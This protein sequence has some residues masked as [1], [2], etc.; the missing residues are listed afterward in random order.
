[1]IAN[2]K[3]EIPFVILILPFL[4][5]ITIGLNFPLTSGIYWLS[6]IFVFLGIAFI[7]L[8][9]TYSR[10]KLYRI[11]WAGG[12]ILHI[13]LFL[14]G[15]ICV[16]SYNELNNNHHFTKA[17]GQYLAV[18]INN[19]PNIRN[20][21]IRF[22]ADV[23][24]RIS[25][26]KQQATTGTLLIAIKDT[27]AYNVY[28]GDQLLIPANYTP[29]EPPYNPA[30]FNYKK[31]LANQNIYYQ[32]FLYPKQFKIL[33][34][35]AGNR[36][37][38]FSLHLRQ[39]LVGK[40]K[41]NMPDT[42][43]IAVASTLIL[44]YKADLSNDILQAYSKTGTIHVLSVSGAHVAIIYI[45]LNLMLGFLNKLPRGKLIKALLIITL[46]WYYSLLSGFSPAV[47]RA[48]VMISMVIIGKTYS[49]YINT[50][51]IL[52]ISAFGLLL[53]D[54]LFITDVG[55][56]LSYLAVAGLIIFQPMVYK[57]WSF[58]NK[59]SDK[60]WVLCS[61]SIAAQVITFPLSAFYFHQFPVYFLVSNLF[62]I[63]P[64]AVIMYTGI[65]YLLL[66]QIPFVSK[67]LGYILD[68][69]IVLM[70]KVLALIEHAPFA[71]IGKIW[72]TTT[73]YLLAYVII[74][75]LFYFLFD[76]K[77]WKLRLTLLATLL[78]CIS[79]SVK[80][81]RVFNHDQIALLNL[82]KH[83]ALIFKTGNNAVVLT[84]LK[85]DNKNYQYA[86][87]P[88]LDSNKV[89]AS[90]L[91]D[92]NNDVDTGFFIKTANLIQFNRQ[93]IVV[94]NKQLQNKLLPQKIKVDYIYV[95]DNPKTDLATINKSFDY[96]YL[97]IDAS[98]TDRL[99][100]NLESQAQAQ[101]VN[102]KVLKRNNS[103]IIASN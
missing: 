48:A 38:A 1:M 99:V 56:Q 12:L 41:R 50:L 45:L 13:I 4:L 17:P 40:L 67:C 71:S 51:N 64:S 32:A 54:P 82:K 35:D 19:E 69:S 23:I 83:R 3:G 46:I 73:E 70:N 59:W 66:P 61:V 37:I 11:N 30:E 96:K 100:K 24:E 98:N 43:A 8:N 91:I 63:I 2:H 90:C 22:T 76:P 10:L 39:R 85:A 84:D 26:G 25:N 7:T 14:A 92:I 9:L 16:I 97:I 81:I 88:Y 55:F 20:G 28:Y 87:Q 77:K 86:V 34:H 74:I 27:S 29:I 93:R 75:M 58:K 65:L 36:I 72:L 60:L 95:T 44:G 102:Y 5:G 52:A 80:R 31:Y 53:F 101:H 18:Q 33:G 21:I 94:L 42:A 78:L 79:I 103:A 47:C 15:Y 89:A 49:R 57:W 62:I 68:K 6:A